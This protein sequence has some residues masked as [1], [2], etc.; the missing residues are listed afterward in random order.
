MFTI[1]IS[2]AMAIVLAILATGEA[3]AADNEKGPNGGHLVDVADR[4]HLE[5][6]V[7]GQELRLFVSDVKDRRIPVDGAAAKATVISAGGKST[8]ALKPAGD[9][10]LKGTGTFA[11]AATMKVDVALT[12]P[13]SPTPVIAK[14]QPLAV[15]GAHSHDHKGHKH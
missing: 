3:I 1:K 13:G 4:F 6:V 11:R 12:L 7:G 2:A 15:S 8:V 9:G 14:F 5:L 10:V